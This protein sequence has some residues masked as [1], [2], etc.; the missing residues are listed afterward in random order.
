MKN[1]VEQIEFALT[2]IISQ[3]ERISFSSSLSAEDMVL[4]HIIATRKLPIDVFTLDTGR[5]HEETYQLMA[6]VQEKY[7]NQLEIYFPEGNDLESF[8][9]REGPNAF[10]QSIDFRKICCRIRNINLLAR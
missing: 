8:M 1:K 7:D 2:D 3:Y 5:L 6:K 4:S 9:N 10:Y